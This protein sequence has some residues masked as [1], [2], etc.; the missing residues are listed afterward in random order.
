[1]RANPTLIARISAARPKV[2]DYPFTTLVPHLGV[3]ELPGGLRGE[4]TLVVADLP[5]LIEG[6]HQGAGL[7]IRF[8]RHRTDP[9]PAVRGG[10]G[11]RCRSGRGRAARSRPSGRARPAVRRARS[12]RP[13]L[14]ERPQLVALN[15]M[16]LP[17][18]KAESD[19][20]VQAFAA[21]GLFVAVPISALTGQGIPVLLEAV[22]DAVKRAPPGSALAPVTTVGSPPGGSGGDR[23]TPAGRD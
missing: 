12:F 2:A 3:A 10:G 9:V 17:W 13:D 14:L 11:A 23:P 15:K 20:L 16:D 1:M 18:A 19:R 7:G 21:R 5:G 8:L 22:W 6:A 4:R